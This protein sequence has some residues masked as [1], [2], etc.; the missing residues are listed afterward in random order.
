M[1][2]NRGCEGAPGSA[3]VGKEGV[4]G[5]DTDRGKQSWVEGEAKPMPPTHRRRERERA[6]RP[7]AI[8]PPERE[9]QRGREGVC[10]GGGR[11][12]G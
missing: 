6:G 12:A 8:H 2:S 1:R 11:T 3:S 10:V 7:C 5:E 9:G 4:E